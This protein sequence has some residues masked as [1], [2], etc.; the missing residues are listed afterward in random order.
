MP[1][2]YSPNLRVELIANGEQASVWGSTTNKNLGTLLEGAIAGRSAVSVTSA[3]QALTALNGADDQARDAILT[4]TTTTTANFAVYAPPASKLYV[5][6]NTTAYTA[7][8][9][10][11]TVIGNTT[12]AGSGVAIPAGKTM[13]V[14]S[15]GTN[16]VVQN[17]HHI[18]TVVGDVTGNL[19][20][21]LTAAAPTAATAAPGTNT[22]QIATSA[23]V[24]AAI[25]AAVAATKEALYPIGSI[26]TN[27]AVTTNPATLLGFGTWAEF[28]SGRVMVGQNTGDTS[29][30]T[31]QETGG[32]KDAIVVS[33]THSVSGTADSTSITG[34]WRQSKPNPSPTGVFSTGATGLSGAADGDQSSGYRVDMNATHTHTFS[35]TTSSTGDGA[36]NANLQPYIVV[37][38]W[39]RT[40]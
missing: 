15:D 27:A 9:Y 11:S 19:A 4:L 37:K 20:G 32:S 28:G 26:Y 13:A 10:N 40:A 36:A 8:I 30:D 34:S 5:V 39:R 7:T 1:S 38:M 35:G 14:M 24:Q 16:M 29:F 17:S 12:A 33:H 23:F 3:D 6:Q 21:N 2:T 18:G 22:T 25:T 31:L